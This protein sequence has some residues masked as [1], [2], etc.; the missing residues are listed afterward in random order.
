MISSYYYK[1]GRKYN[2]IKKLN[3]IRGSPLSSNKGFVPMYNSDKVEYLNSFSDKN[4]LIS[5][6]MSIYKDFDLIKAYFD[7]G[8]KDPAIN[9]C[10]SKCAYYKNGYNADIIETYWFLL[11]SNAHKKFMTWAL[12]TF[13]SESGIRFSTYYNNIFPDC[14]HKEF[15]ELLRSG[16]LNDIGDESFIP[17]SCL[18]DICDDSR[19]LSLE[20]ITRI[21]GKLYEST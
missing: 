10:L 11:L 7:N 6:L 13:D 12:P 18:D 9:A 17:F 3:Y 5:Y 15:L 16:I 20:F 2:K 19:I 8:Y 14:F 1:L 21:N 4:R